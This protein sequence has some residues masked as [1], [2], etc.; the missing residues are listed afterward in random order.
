MPRSPQFVVQLHQAS[1]LHYDFRLEVDGVL[2]SWAV[3]KGPSADPAQRRLAVEV[4]D[5]AKGWG[6]FE[7]RIGSGYGKGAVIVWDRGT[8]E[9]LDDVPMAEALEAGHAKFRLAG[10]KLRGGWLLQRTRDGAKP[11]WLLV[12]LRDEDADPERDLGAE[13]RS[14]VSGKTIDEL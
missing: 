5:H 3:P 9:P 7:G 1:T 13:A 10:E 14:V 11:Q 2:R 12:K 6:R 8:Y 4:D